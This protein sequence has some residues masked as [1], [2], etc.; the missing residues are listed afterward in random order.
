MFRVTFAGGGVM[1]FIGYDDIRELVTDVSDLWV[2]HC[3]DIIKVE[4]FDTL[5]EL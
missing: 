4:R 3:G 5:D 2:P 1:R